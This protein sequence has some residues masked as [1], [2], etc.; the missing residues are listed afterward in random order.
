MTSLGGIFNKNS[1]YVMFELFQNIPLLAMINIVDVSVVNSN[2]IWH[3]ILFK[4]DR[5]DR[6]NSVKKNTVEL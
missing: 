2:Q 5:R 3:C 4:R 6:I 1:K